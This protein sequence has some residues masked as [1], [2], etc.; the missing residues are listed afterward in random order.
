MGINLSTPQLIMTGLQNLIETAFDSLK[1]I[2]R[3]NMSLDEVAETYSPIIDDIIKKY[4]KEN[5]TFSAGKFK[6]SRVDE[7]KFNLGF[8]L[9]FQDAEKNWSKVAKTSNPMSGQDWLSPEGW[10]E[11]QNLKEKVYDVTAPK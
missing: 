8:E 2:F 10:L 3:P 7:K 5:V 11:L 4:E 9:Y 6:I 1:E